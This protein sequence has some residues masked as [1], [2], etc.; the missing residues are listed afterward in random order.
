VAAARELVDRVLAELAARPWPASTYRLQLGGGQG[1]REA[2]ALAPYL[3][4]LGVTHLYLSPIFAAAPGSTHG[5]DV[6]DHNTLSAELGGEEGYAALLAACRAA[7]LEVMLDW[8]PN[9]MG[10]GRANA[11]WQDVLENGPSSLY[12]P[13]FDID[14]RPVK[15]ELANKVLVPTL[16]DQF[17]EVLERGELRLERDGGAFHVAYYDHH[18]PVAPRSVPKILNLRL[19]ELRQALGPE[20]LDLAELLS[21]VT[22]LEKLPPRHI[23]EPENVVERAREKEVAKRRLA[24]LFERNAALREHIDE[25]VRIYNGTVGEPRS[26]DALE[27]LLEGLA[28]RLADWRVAGEEINY[29][30][31]FDINALAAIRMEDEEV[32]ARTHKT[33][34]AM[35]TD[36]RAHALRI[37]HPD[38]LYQPTRYFEKLQQ[39]YVRAFVLALP[40]AAGADP[41]EIDAA[42]RRA[43]DEKR[44]GCPLVVVVEKI[45]GP[46]EIMPESWCVGGTTGYEFLAAAGGLHVARE[47]E[48][49]FNA[50]Y[51]RFTGERVHFEEMVAPCK[52]LIM[53]TSMA[54]EINMLSHRLNRLSEEDR[55]TRD[56]T[57]NSLA[58]A[59][60]HVIAELP[61]YRTYIEGATAA[62]VEPRDR[63]YV[64]ETIAAAMRRAPSMNASIFEFLRD[65]LLLRLPE[66]MTP[67]QRQAFVEFVR[68]VQQVTGPVTAKSVE[69]TA[70]YRYNRL[71]ALNEVGG[72]PERFG[73]SVEDFHALNQH[74]L[75]RWPVSLNSTSTHD[76][77][78]SEDVRLTIAALSE[79]PGEWIEKLRRF[80]R[81]NRQHKT[82]VD[83]EAAPDRN[84]EM[85]FYQ[86]LI[87]AL[88]DGGVDDAFIAR[89]Q[90]YM[91]KATRE[92]KVHTA[93]TNPHAAY[94]EAIRKFVDATLRARTF[95]DELAP[96]QRRL[97]RAA[98]VASLAVTACKIAAPGVP[99]VYQGCELTDLSLVDPDNRRPVDFARR[100][101]LLDELARQAGD[102]EARRRAAREAATGGLDA[103]VAKLMLLRAGLRLRR[104]ARALFLRGAY[105][106]LEARGRDAAHVVAF[107]RRHEGRLVVCVTPRLLLSKA[108]GW[109]GEVL[110]PEA[111][112]RLSCVVSGVE[113]TARDGGALALAD[114]FAG[115]PVALLTA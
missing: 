46:G 83:G 70:F 102:P 68:K 30:R 91:E 74:R 16:G 49:A 23:V 73:T 111:P 21:I 82:I 28:Y 92:A 1:F 65:I 110:L 61:I 104:D 53:S 51:A 3:A 13:C 22:A 67:R 9:H 89:M 58:E 94:D 32:F 109:E 40:E 101:A 34:L 76:T 97:A 27:Q 84:E 59:L 113:V 18:F 71:L 52:R 25:N 7:G 24:A 93:W 107:A 29:R 44:A 45:L 72:E 106:P 5:Y 75:A 69:D 19:A 112:P 100:R 99:D 26:F 114:C 55:K 38:G 43:F 31:F 90:L 105:L 88:P 47:A 50:L 60:T 37:D 20:D 98:R 8:V 41:A 14:W 15:V 36:G 86:S 48:R 57:L 95:L 56:F 33:L 2:A 115:F 108:E 6:V 39:A 12:A 81:L 77:K 10:I 78:R 63:R 80:A 66:T 62:D 87:G 4:D 17:G 35:L 103:G 85:L 54:S 96:F 79:V 64:E 11:W 42:V